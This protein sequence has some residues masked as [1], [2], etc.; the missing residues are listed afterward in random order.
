MNV[1]QLTLVL[2]LASACIFV[3][4]CSRGAPPP[5]ATNVLDRLLLS[6]AEINTAI[7]TTRILANGTYVGMNDKSQYPGQGLPIPGPSG[8]LGL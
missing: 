2:A 8:G 6:P 1:R 5:V 4:S 7:G 3:S